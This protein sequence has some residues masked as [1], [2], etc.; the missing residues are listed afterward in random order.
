MLHLQRCSRWNFHRSRMCYLHLSILCLMAISPQKSSGS[1][2]RDRFW[3]HYLTVLKYHNFT[4]RT[5]KQRYHTNQPS[6]S[7]AVRFALLCPVS[8]I[9]QVLFYFKFID[10]NGNCWFDVSYFPYYIF[11]LEFSLYS[12]FLCQEALRVLLYW[13]ALNQ[14]LPRLWLIEQEEKKKQKPGDMFPCCFC[15]ECCL[16]THFI[17]HNY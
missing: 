17:G 11:K 15:T 4:L 8:F 6:P 2:K 13:P 14:R 7:A 5:M 9:V 1:W 16:F 12:L 3:H 10:L